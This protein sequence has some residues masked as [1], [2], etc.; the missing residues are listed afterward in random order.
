M[1]INCEFS[2]SKK[3]R[4]QAWELH[5]QLYRKINKNQFIIEY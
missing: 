4:G 5:S 3:I 2:E 1:N